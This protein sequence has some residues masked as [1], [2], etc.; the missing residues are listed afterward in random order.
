VALVGGKAIAVDLTKKAPGDSEDIKP[1]YVPTPQK[2]V[3]EMCKLAKVGK[4]DVV[5]DIGCGDG[6]LVITAVKQFKAKKGV[7][8]DIR[9]ELVKKCKDNAKKA[10]VDDRTEFRAADAL[11][12]KDFSEATVVLL[13]LGDHLNLALRPTLRKTLKPGARV[14]SHRFLMGD[15]KPDRTVELRAKNLSDELDDYKLH[16]WT[17][18]KP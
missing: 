2:V 1:I 11:K 16:L 7:G 18:K 10:G 4:D 17:I 13:Y 14:V 12:I 8:I 15:W 6:R 9:A 3:E 5:Y